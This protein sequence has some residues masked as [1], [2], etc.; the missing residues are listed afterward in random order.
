MIAPTQSN[1]KH[2]EVTKFIHLVLMT[3]YLSRLQ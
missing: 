1:D 3:V 2:N